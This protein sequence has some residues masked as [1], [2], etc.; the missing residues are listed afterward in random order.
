MVRINQPEPVMYSSLGL[1]ALCQRIEPTGSCD[2]LELGPARTGNVE[3][4]SRFTPSLFVADLRSSLPLPS[5]PPSEDSEFLE[6]D[7]DGVL[8][9]PAGRTYDVVLAW[10]LLN[11]LEL[12]AAASMVKYLNHF[13]HPGTIFFTLIFDQKQ[14]PEKIAV[15]NITDESH[16]RYEYF[17]SDMRTC[18][19]HN[20]H[21]LAGVMHR[22]RS[23]DSFR[24]RN[25]IIEYLFV[26]Q[27]D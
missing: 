20:A 25:G 9:L 19:R 1:Q 21:D 4:W 16:L 18:P 3:F 2:I 23:A 8:G 6:P 27:G 14:M 10:D 12:P 7:W 26:Y 11:Y 17:S 13:C 15:Y 22:F 24:L 5:L